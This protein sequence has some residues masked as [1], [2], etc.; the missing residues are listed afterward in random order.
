MNTQ[1][2]KKLL[3]ELR[4]K[5]NPIVLI[6]DYHLA[7]LPAMIKKARPDV[8]IGLFWHIPWTSPESFSICPQK[9]EI[10]SGMLGADIIGFHTQQYGNNFMDTVSRELE[11]RVDFDQFSVV[12]K[13][14]TSFV[15]PF[16]ISVDFTGKNNH[17]FTP[18]ETSATL[19]KFH[20]STKYFALGVDRMDYT[21]GLLERFKAIE[22]FLD[23]HEEYRDNF[24]FLQIAA[25]SRE[26]VPYYQQFSLDV[27]GEAERINQ[28]FGNN[29]WKPIILLNEHFSHEEIHPLYAIADVCM[30]TSLHDGMNLVAK[31]FIAAQSQK[32]GMLILSQFAGAARELKDALI[33]NPYSAEETS[34]A[35]YRAI[36]MT[37][38]ERAMRMDRMRKIIMNYNVYRWSAELIKSIVD[39]V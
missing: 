33:V 20:I 12:H 11:A 13:E 17:I 37:V 26:A 10:L 1:F 31:E 27:H 24:T 21:K 22:F 4:G 34:S 29:K 6:Q 23:A 5:K 2:A 8:K 25:P 35:L 7:L 36:N 14:H 30:V 3:E 9:K 39:I 18:E 16:P 28:R 38:S 32:N 19:K 15:K